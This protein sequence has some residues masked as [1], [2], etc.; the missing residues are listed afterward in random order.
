MTTFKEFIED[1]ER[2]A[3]EEG[4]AAIQE[5]RLWRDRFR[6]IAKSAVREAKTVWE[7]RR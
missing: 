7:N 2:E 1:I 6:K 4:K 3:K 5:M